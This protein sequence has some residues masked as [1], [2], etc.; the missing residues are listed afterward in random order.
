MKK[1]MTMSL[2]KKN[3]NIQRV[4][5]EVN[6]WSV[7]VLSLPISS[8]HLN[9]IRSAVLLCCVILAYY[10]TVPYSLISS[11][12]AA[13]RKAVL[14]AHTEPFRNPLAIT[15]IQLVKVRNGQGKSLVRF[16]N[17]FKRCALKS[18]ANF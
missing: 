3:C 11:I 2:F 12:S 4:T 13:P 18:Y 14:Q 17:V 6:I 9:S 10:G 7:R 16:Q 5:L 8:R 1:T 15:K